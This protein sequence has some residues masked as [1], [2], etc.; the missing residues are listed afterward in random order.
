MSSDLAQPLDVGSNHIVLL[1][2]DLHETLHGVL[3]HVLA[4]RLEGLIKNLLH[5]E[6]ALLGHLEIGSRVRD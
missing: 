2:A 6:V 3:S 5:D 1:L 4:A